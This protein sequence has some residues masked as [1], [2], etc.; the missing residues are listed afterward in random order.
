MSRRRMRRHGFRLS[1]NR[2]LTGGRPAR[3]RHRRL[4]LSPSRE[5][6]RPWARSFAAHG[7]ASIQPAGGS[8]CDTPPFKPFPRRL[9]LTTAFDRHSTQPTTLRKTNTIEF[10]WDARKT[11]GLRMEPLIPAWAR[12]GYPSVQLSDFQS[13]SDVSRWARCACYSPRTRGPR[14][15]WTRKINQWKQLPDPADRVTA[16]LRYVQERHPSTRRARTTMRSAMN[17]RSQSVVFARVASG[18][19]KDKSFLL[20]TMLRAP[21]DRSSSQCWSTTALGKEFAALLP[22]PLAFNR[23]IVQ[24]NLGGRNF[25]LDPTA[26]YERGSLALR[27]WPSYGWGL[28]VG[29]PANAWTPGPTGLTPIPPCPVN[30]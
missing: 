21:P 9:F 8:G 23:V 30:A 28:M 16:A 20:V 3:G 19:D 13:W 2:R 5:E 6:I 17:R 25:W 14:W 11:P 29:R 1:E 22:S 26:S 10:A 18:N 27:Y 24:V 7:G 12:S 15:S 4:R